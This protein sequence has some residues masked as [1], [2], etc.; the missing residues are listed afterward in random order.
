M[1]VS[2]VFREAINVEKVGEY[3]FWEGW[4]EEVVNNVNHLFTQYGLLS[5]DSVNCL[6]GLERAPRSPTD[7]ISTTRNMLIL[8][9][10]E[11]T[12]IWICIFA[13]ILCHHFVDLKLEPFK[14][15][16]DDDGDDARDWR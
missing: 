2:F 1:V 12:T 5:R 4:V 13:F 8:D 10:F 6:F 15:D 11:Q 14:D 9:E 16:L 7:L 3:V